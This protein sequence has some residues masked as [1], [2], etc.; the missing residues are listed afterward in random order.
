MGIT[1][2]RFSE[3]PVRNCQLQYTSGVEM[4]KK[5]AGGLVLILGAAG[6]QG[7]IHDVV[8]SSLTPPRSF[9]WNSHRGMAN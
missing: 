2:H 3:R 6:E 8:P 7:G 9:R 5:N 1:S 4:I